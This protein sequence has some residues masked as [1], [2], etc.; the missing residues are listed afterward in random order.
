MNDT[1]W[2]GSEQSY[3]DTKDAI[4]KVA[5][6]YEAH[7][8]AR[9][10]ASSDDSDENEVR[11]PYMEVVDGVAVI[12]V[13]GGLYDATFGR[14]GQWYGIC[15]YGDI[16]EALV[17]AV[18]NYDVKSIMLVIKSGGGSVSGCA[19][20]AKFIS[21]VDTVKPVFTYSPSQMCSAA[22]WLGLGAR[23]VY[24]GDASLVGSIGTISMVV[25]RHR[26]LQEEGIDVEIVRSGKYKALGHPAEAMS[27]LAVED[28]K[29]RV[30]YF[31]DLFNEYVAERRGTT[32]ANVD[33]RYG[34][35]RVF[36]GKQALDVGLIDGVMDYSSAYSATKSAAPTVNNARFVA[37]NVVPAVSAVHNGT[38]VQGTTMPKPH[39]PSPAELAAMAAGVDLQTDAADNQPA[40]EG[41]EGAATA[42]FA[43]I[44][45][46]QAELAEA[47]AKITA[48]EAGVAE[49]TEKLTTAEAGLT[50]A[51][52]STAD[53]IKIAA[54]TIRTMQIGLNQKADD[55]Q[56]KTAD[57]VVALHKEVS[58]SFVAKFKVGG[59]AATEKE[60][61]AEQTTASQ[62]APNHLFMAAAKLRQT[63]G[64][65][66]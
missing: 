51:Q 26:M 16:R 42:D 54:G 32:V 13:E 46:L 56:A 40:A 5:A 15:G 22:L 30:M 2:L 44:A 60:T 23:K 11:S 66:A 34:Q 10:T 43:D 4:A 17:E 12:S 49:L 53:L 9:V 58:A 47:Q 45:A 38:E 19:D 65:G 24:A 7:P 39:I 57:E 48:A 31:A 20:T 1:Y 29:S 18:K 37:A 25:S 62:A 64:K 52:A 33:S 41:Q 8:E 3:H 59:V 55:L 35:G 14:V 61:Q 28:T 36:I 50:A 6:Y 63:Q 21:Q 27:E